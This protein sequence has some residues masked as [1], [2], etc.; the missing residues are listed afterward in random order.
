MIIDSL[1]GMRDKPAF[2]ALMRSTRELRQLGSR[3]VKALVVRDHQALVLFPRMATLEK[4]R[5]RLDLESAKEWLQ[6]VE[7]AAQ[8]GSACMLA[9]CG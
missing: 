2:C 5:I 9:N 1:F 4:L 8:V 6:V 7:T 3:H